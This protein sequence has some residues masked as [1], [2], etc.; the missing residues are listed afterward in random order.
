MWEGSP[1]DIAWYPPD[2]EDKKSKFNGFLQNRAPPP[3]HL[4]KIPAIVQE[5]NKLAP[6]GNGFSAWG[7]MG[8]CWGGKIA[9]LLAGKDSLFKVAIQCHP[10]MVDAKDAENVAIPMAMLA[11]KDEPA[12]D[13]K[14]YKE[15]LKVPHFVET[16][17]TQVHGWMA[18]RADLGDEEVK[19]EYENGYKVALGFLREHM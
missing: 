1:A 2:T 8:H 7:V 13:V 10:A 14:A 12:E 4:P 11:S 19:R 5:A 17:T 6:G 15:A 18:A 3:L 16:W 9:T